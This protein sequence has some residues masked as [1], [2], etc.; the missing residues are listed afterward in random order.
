MKEESLDF[1]TSPRL[2]MEI[3]EEARIFPSKS[4]HMSGG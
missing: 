4:G 2:T 1:L 3:K